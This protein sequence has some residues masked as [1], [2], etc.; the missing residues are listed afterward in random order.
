MLVLCLFISKTD[1]FFFFFVCL[2]IAKKQRTIQVMDIHELPKSKAKNGYF[3]KNRGG[4]S[5]QGRQ[6][7]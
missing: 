1:M 4:G 2:F 5:S 3:P 6:H 7:W